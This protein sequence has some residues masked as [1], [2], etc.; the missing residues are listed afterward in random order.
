MP[1]LPEEI[2]EVFAYFMT[3]YAIDSPPALLADKVQEILER[4]LRPERA[5][6]LTRKFLI[7]IQRKLVDEFNERFGCQSSLRF[8]IID[9]D[10]DKIAGI[11]DLAETEKIEFQD[12]INRLSHSEFEGLSALVL[13]EAGCTFLRRTP[14]SHDQGIDAFGYMGILGA[15][16]DLHLINTPRITFLAQ[17]KHYSKCKIGSKDVRE[18]VGTYTLALHK[19]Y[20]TVD[21]RYEELDFA[22][23]SP[24][25]LIFVTSEEIPSTVKRMAE[26]SGMIALSSDDLFRIFGEQ[27]ARKG[28]KVTK[29]NLATTWIPKMRAIPVAK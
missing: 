5:E 3:E 23:L 29:D 16:T 6:E 10:G 1:D 28:L 21:N 9:T 11:G 2:N 19:I 14:E 8:Q 12:A 17:A 25:C 27:A 4:N 7:N 15:D 24:V 18:F 20:S 26:R 22:P 13:E